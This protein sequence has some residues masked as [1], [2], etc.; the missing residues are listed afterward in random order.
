MSGI[1]KIQKGDSPW[2]VAVTNLKARGVK[3]DNNAIVKEMQRLAQLN[4]CK[5][6]EDLSSKFFNRIGLELKTDSNS[7]VKAQGQT[8]GTAVKRKTPTNV[9]TVNRVTQTIANQGHRSSVIN[10]NQLTQNQ[11]KQIESYQYL[12][13]VEA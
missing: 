3:T 7:Q 4:G 13:K 6:V 5:N 12:Y 11:Q 10:R 8:Q 1:H 2:K 9:N